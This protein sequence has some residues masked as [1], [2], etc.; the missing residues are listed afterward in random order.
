VAAKLGKYVRE[1]EY[2]EPLP[3]FLQ[4]CNLSRSP[5][6]SLPLSQIHLNCMKFIGT[7]ELTAKLRKRQTLLMK[8]NSTSLEAL[9]F[10]V[11][12]PIPGWLLYLLVALLTLQA[13]EVP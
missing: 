1:Q 7:D 4:Y 5:S 10:Q 6:L 2:T 12:L 13:V 11:P 8:P 9:Q 3:R